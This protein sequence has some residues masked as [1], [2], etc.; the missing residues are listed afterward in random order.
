MVAKVND[1]IF[2]MR[3]SCDPLRARASGSALFL[4]IPA[5]LLCTL[6]KY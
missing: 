6:T 2:R 5:A 1:E 3:P 4:G